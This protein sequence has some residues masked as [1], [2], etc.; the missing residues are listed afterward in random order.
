PILRRLR[1]PAR[2]PAF[3]ALTA[4]LGALGD[5]AALVDALRE[6][7]QRGRLVPWIGPDL[8]ASLTGLTSRGDVALGLARAYDRPAADSLA[9]AAAQVMLHD[10]DRFSFTDYMRRALN[11][12]LV[13]P[14]A[15]YRALARLDVPLWLSAAYD[16][17]LARALGAVNTVVAGSDTRYWR[18]DR[19]TV[20]RVLGDLAANRDVVVLE[21][22]YEALREQ[23]G[24]RRLLL[25]FL[26]E[27]LAGRVVLLLGHDPASQDFALLCR[28]VLDRHLADVDAQAFLVWPTDG[29]VHT[30]AGRPIYQLCQDPLALVE[31]LVQD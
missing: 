1:D 8:P 25:A 27:Q 17:Q 20:V 29:P 23:E 21:R 3:L 18:A 7:R 16:G 14:G 4:A 9:R 31:A 28:Y 19:P 2:E 13:S 11:D 15:I 5:P 6:I 12:Q 30:W 22:D 26:R 24:E 10:R